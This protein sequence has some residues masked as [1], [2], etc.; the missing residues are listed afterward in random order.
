[1]RGSMGCAIAVW[2]VLLRELMSNW[3]K[4]QEEQLP[5]NLGS[6]RQEQCSVPPGLWAGF[7]TA[8][9]PMH[10]LIPWECFH[11]PCHAAVLASLLALPETITRF[12]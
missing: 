2:P 9:V 11:V 6:P 10:W 7:G 1:M 8:R 4:E 3:L 5:P 12:H